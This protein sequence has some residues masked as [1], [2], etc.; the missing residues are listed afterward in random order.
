LCE[1]QPATGRMVDG[2]SRNQCNLLNL[3]RKRWLD[4]RFFWWRSIA[5]TNCVRTNYQVPCR[6]N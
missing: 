3:K 5:S 4:W 6:K 1:F 2:T